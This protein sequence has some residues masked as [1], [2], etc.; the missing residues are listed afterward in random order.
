MKGKFSR[1]IIT[2]LVVISVV[3]SFTLLPVHV[4]AAKGYPHEHTAVDGICTDCGMPEEVICYIYKDEARLC[5]WDKASFSHKE[6]IDFIIPETVEGIPLVEIE[7][8]IFWKVERIKNVIIS[9]NMKRIGIGAFLQCPN[10]ESVTI[11]A[12]V[13]TIELTPFAGCPKLKK[14]TVHKDNKNY[15]SDENGVLYNKDK[16]I[17]IQY[18]CGN[19]DTSYVI[20]SGV[21]RVEYG[22]F[23]MANNLRYIV[24]SDT[25]EYLGHRLFTMAENLEA[26]YI[27]KSVTSF[28]IE[29]ILWT[30]N[31]S[32]I[33]YEGTEEEWNSIENIE[34][35]APENTIIHYRVSADDFFLKNEVKATCTEKGYSGDWYCNECEAIIQKG[36]ETELIGHSYEIL[37]EGDKIAA[38]CTQC[39]DSYETPVSEENTVEINISSYSDD[40]VKIVFENKDKSGDSYSTVASNN[41]GIYSVHGINKGDYT[42]KLSKPDHVTRKYDITIGEDNP[43][44]N[45]KLNLI[46][47]VNGDGSI[48]VI[49]YTNTLK[50][51]KK[52]AMLNGYEFDCADVNG[53]EKISIV[54]YTRILKHVKKTD[55]LW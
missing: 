10:L 11:P 46:G 18:P 54:D 44:L 24:F 47:D 30:D 27:P 52:T 50:H 48:S 29:A 43:D 37:Q 1:K 2:V 22:S 4:S 39:D 14:I 53:D 23:I 15:C 26:I 38:Q 36:S 7:D 51:V 25:V 35:Q 32:H 20:P 3:L 49:D 21:E 12:S 41:S 31:F 19:E 28:G 34:G 13:E 33:M 17:L 55:M 9:E 40:D 5:D 45:F 6:L 16:T 42:A 8:D